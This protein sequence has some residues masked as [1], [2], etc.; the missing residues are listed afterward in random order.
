[1]RYRHRITGPWLLTG[2]LVLLLPLIAAC[3]GRD[4]APAASGEQQV[5]KPTSDTAAEQIVPVEGQA[6]SGQDR[7]TQAGTPALLAF[8][9]LG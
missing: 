6:F 7:A 9:A 3:G 1:M 5:T 4:T 2:L 8:D